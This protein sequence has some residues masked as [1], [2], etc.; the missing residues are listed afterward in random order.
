MQYEL[1]FLLTS[2]EETKPVKTLLESLS[3]K[4]LKEEKWGKKTLAYPIKKNH[5][6][7]FFNWAF[8]MDEK[9]VTEF[10]KKLNFNEKLVRYLL[11]QKEISNVKAQIS[12][13]QRKSE[14][15]VKKI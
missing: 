13:P 1:T 7:L 9:K 8:E 10:R 6:L 4:I 2:E 11:L 5:S 15:L 14:N 12:K 3:G